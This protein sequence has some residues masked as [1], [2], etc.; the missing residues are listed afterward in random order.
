M[1]TEQLPTE[2]ELEELLRDDPRCFIEA[3]HEYFARSLVSYIKRKSWGVLDPHELKDAYQETM[4]AVWRRLQEPGVDP[5][6]PLRLVQAIARNIAVTMRRRKF[7]RRVRPNQEAV[8]N[9]VAA[10]LA[11]TTIGLEWRLLLPEERREFQQA[12]E[13]IIASLPERQRM[14]AQAFAETYEELRERDK[15]RPLA[16]AMSAISGKTEDVATAKSA[17]RFARE[18]IQDKLAQRGFGF[19]KGRT[20]DGSHWR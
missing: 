4:L 9:A 7:G 3:L 16:A 1:P 11:G 8:V 2:E 5:H 6:R 13:E 12:V 20:D 15:Y 18:T 10:D 19:M 17:W 14:A